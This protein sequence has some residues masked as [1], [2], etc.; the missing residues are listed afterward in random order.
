MSMQWVAMTTG[1]YWNGD[2]A[3]KLCM[4]PAYGTWTAFRE[5]AVLGTR[6]QRGSSAPLAPPPCPCPV[7]EEERS[8]ARAIFGRA[9]RTSSSEGD[10]YV[11]TLD[12]SW[13]ELR[14]Y[15]RRAACRGS[16]REEV[17]DSGMRRFFVHCTPE[18]NEV[19]RKTQYQNTYL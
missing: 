16:E 14:D 5:V 3:T 13:E 2:E 10:G 17:S 18:R 1:E 7:S 19:T 6:V 9:M 15:L 8:A 11:A 12:R 4:H